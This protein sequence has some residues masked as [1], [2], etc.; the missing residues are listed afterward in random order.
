MS[1]MIGC[2][3]LITTDAWFFAPDGEMYRAVFGTVKGILNTEDALGIKTNS[4]STN[5][6]VQIGNTMIAGCQI[7]Y[8]IRTD[9]V[10]FECPTREIEH[11]GVLHTT[12]CPQ[13]RIFNADKYED[14]LWNEKKAG[15]S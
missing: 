4:G 11:E 6:Y 7:H 10:S 1:N 8:V 13:T 9:E 12:S 2:K 15:P 5:W 3:V 14:D